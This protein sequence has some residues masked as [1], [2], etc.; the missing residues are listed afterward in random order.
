L[1][2]LIGE[3][4]CQLSKIDKGTKPISFNPTQ[5]EST[6]LD[7]SAMQHTRIVRLEKSEPLINT[8][9]LRNEI[10]TACKNL[11]I[12][13]VDS[14]EENV[15]FATRSSLSGLTVGDNQYQFSPYTRSSLTCPHGGGIVGVH[16]QCHPDCFYQLCNPNGGKWC[17]YTATHCPMVTTSCWQH[18]SNIPLNCR[19]CCSHPKVPCGTQFP[20]CGCY[21]NSQNGK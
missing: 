6:P 15:Y 16:I 21:A 8:S 2:K 17:Y 3:N 5:R 7:S 20:Y 1:V 14:V 19:P 12:F 9:Y 4:K 18:L 11:P 10:Q 13:W